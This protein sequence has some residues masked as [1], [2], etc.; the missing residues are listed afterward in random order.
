VSQFADRLV[1]AIKEKGN[2]CVVGLDPRV[3]QMPEFATARLRQS[4]DSDL[5]APTIT[6]FHELVLSAVADLVPT[7]KLQCA[8]F[9]QYGLPGMRALAETIRLAKSAGLIVIVDAKRN[10]IGSTAEAYANAF[11]GPRNAFEIPVPNWD[12]DCITVS[13]LLGRDSLE[14][15]VAACRQHDRGIFVLVKTSNPGSLDFQD[16]LTDAGP[17]ISNE[18]ARLV[19]EIGSGLVGESGFSAV[20]A[21]V[22]ATFP[23][24]AADL[25]RLMPKAFI[26]VPGYGE[27]GG[28]A[29]AAAV[30]LNR[31]GLGALVSAS[32][33]ITYASRDGRIAA[34]DFENLVRENTARMVEDVTQTIRTHIPQRAHATH[35]SDH[36]A[37]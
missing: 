34:K 10:D 33:S 37:A 1:A 23:D 3:E 6:A 18:L 20:G 4:R 14:P 2:P 32:R 8:F 27:Q 21:V 36:S 12:V 30:S 13:P 11:L 9:E 25:R 26:L 29:E 15:F 5:I 22:G 35:S 7:V 24:H 19:D 16:R 28:T 17:P 31:D